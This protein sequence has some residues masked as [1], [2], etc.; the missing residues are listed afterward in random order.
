[1]A[2][3]SAAKKEKQEAEVPEGYERTTA[4]RGAQAWAKFET[5]LRLH[6]KLMGRFSKK[7][8]KGKKRF[9]YMFEAI[10][11]NNKA[12]LKPDRESDAEEITVKEGD[13]FCVDEKY[14]LRDLRKLAGNGA[15]YN[16]IIEVG[17]KID[18]D[19]GN[20]FWPA[21]VF[22]KHVS[23][24]PRPVANVEEP[25]SEDDDTKQDDDIPF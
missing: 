24:K 17:K 23:G 2:K 25:E 19:G 6:G 9:Y 22:H 20:S 10:G 5:G 3:A 16:V 11:N 12:W 18:L 8:K 21:D 1:M 14:T 4:P 13:P 7:D 15:V